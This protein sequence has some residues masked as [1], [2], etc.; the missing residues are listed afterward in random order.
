VARGRCY[1]H[2]F[3]CD[4]WRFSAKKLAFFSKTNVMIKIL[5]NLALFWVKNTI[6]FAEFFGENI[7]KII[8]SVPDEFVK[9]SPKNEAQPIFLFPTLRPQIRYN[10]HVAPAEPRATNRRR[11][12]N[13]PQ[14]GL[15]H[16]DVTFCFMSGLATLEQN[17]L[18]GCSDTPSSARHCYCTYIPLFLH[19]T[20][21]KTEASL[22]LKHLYM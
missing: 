13:S 16:P 21:N 17:V 22:C 15:R 12:S 1:D 19:I 14:D 6:S 2:N 5:H 18:V 3:R 20:G 8:T 11:T 9:K 4:F 10:V 7:L